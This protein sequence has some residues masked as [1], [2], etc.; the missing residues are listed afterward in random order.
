MHRRFLSIAASL[1]VLL[2]AHHDLQGQLFQAAKGP[3]LTEAPSDDPNYILM[4]EFI[5]QIKTGDNESR[6]LGLQI[7][8][9]GNDQF[10]AVSFIGGLPGQ[11]EHQAEPMR[12]IGRRSEDF[13]VL[14]GG[15]WAIFVERDSCLIL[16]RQGNRVGTLERIERVSPTLGAR[17]PENA[18]VLFDGKNTDQFTMAEMTEQG[19]LKEGA[20]V[21][22]MFQDFDL[23]VEFRLPY[24]PEA[25]DQSRGNSGLYLQSRYECQILDSFAQDPVFNGCGALYKFRAPT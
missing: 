3:A 16:D 24:M 21:R 20:N 6:R 12:M 8:P 14:S 1:I 19:W 4:G 23:H 9:V 13:V 25:M 5:G 17:P 7:R 11:D 22:P 10:D 18:T 2:A 15:P